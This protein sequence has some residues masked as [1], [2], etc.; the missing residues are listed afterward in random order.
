MCRPNY[1]FSRLEKMDFNSQRLTLELSMKLSQ[2]FQESYTIRSYSSV[3]DLGSVLKNSGG[4]TTPFP[5]QI[6][7]LLQWL[8]N[9]PICLGFVLEKGEAVATL[10]RYTTD[11]FQDLADC[12][13]KPETRVFSDLCLVICKSAAASQCL[14]C[15]RL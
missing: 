4:T 3:F 2:S 6:S 5:I 1:I 15:S 9:L 14:N 10:S 8:E 11:Q 13:K 12:S 7:C